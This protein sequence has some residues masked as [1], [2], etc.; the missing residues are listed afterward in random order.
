MAEEAAVAGVVAEEVAVLLVLAEVMVVAGIVMLRVV[1][2][3]LFLLVVVVLLVLVEVMV[4]V[5]LAVIFFTRL[6]LCSRHRGKHFSYLIYSPM[7]QRDMHYYPYFID[8]GP[9][10]PPVH[11]SKLNSKAKFTPRSV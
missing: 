10:L 1:E 3:V 9:K 5:V 11:S 4:G 7:T 6:I 2:E 8:V